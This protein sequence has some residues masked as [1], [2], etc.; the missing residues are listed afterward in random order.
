MTV[1]EYI[2]IAFPAIFLILN[3]FSA[4]SSFLTLTQGQSEEA[5]IRTAKRACTS[6]FFILIFFALA[7]HFIFQMFHITISA[8]R[9]AG[10]IIVFQIG[11]NMLKL[12]PLRI[13]QTEE[14]MEES[15]HKQDIAIVPLAMPLLSGPGAITTIMVLTAE[16]NWKLK[17]TGMLQMAG[18]VIA[19]ALS[20]VLIYYLMT[21]S[22]K[23]LEL[24]KITGVGVMTRIM[25]LILTVIAAQFVINGVRDL[26]PE[27]AK[28]LR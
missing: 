18:L 5:Q 12:Q 6:A 4:A 16:I 23:L 17:L 22:R 8:F 9:I 20:L 19:S 2:F 15:L 24:F 10:G 14:E 21:H 28:I 3:P 13:K 1:A 25:G 7:G 11:L 26:L 27:F